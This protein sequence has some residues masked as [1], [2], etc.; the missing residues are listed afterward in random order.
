MIIFETLLCNND[1]NCWEII[2]LWEEEKI[3]EKKD[4]N[5]KKIK[6]KIKKDQDSIMKIKKK[7]KNIKEIDTKTW[8]LIK[9]QNKKNNEKNTENNGIKNQILKIRINT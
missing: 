5:M 7:D 2:I 1:R 6:K 8:L 4:N 3:K 9:K